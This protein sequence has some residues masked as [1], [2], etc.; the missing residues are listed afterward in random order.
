[1]APPVIM[2]AYKR[3][4]AIMTQSIP[5][6]WSIE[7]SDKGW[8]TADSFYEYVANVFYSRL[9]TTLSERISDNETKYILDVFNLIATLCSIKI[10]QY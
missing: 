9:T 7:I 4:P 2:Y 5:K 1:M 8:M 10:K 3:I 6:G